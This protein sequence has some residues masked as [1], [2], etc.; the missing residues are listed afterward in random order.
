MI[1][2]AV[3]ALLGLLLVLR[4]PVALSIFVAAAVG[5]WWIGDL[6]IMWG[7]L[8]STVFTVASYYEF[9]VI[10]MFLLM[11]EL[12]VISGIADDL[13]K[14]AAA[15]VGRLPGGLAV[16]TTVA[17]AGFGAISGSSTACA[18]VLSATSVPAMLR[19][20]YE[21]RLA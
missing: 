10:P 5:L 18:A 9:I 6:R 13:F 4:I 3:V 12:I 7:T 20:G 14:A 19:E 1:A 15:F 2:A 11:A 8:Q 21:P 17:G 16:A